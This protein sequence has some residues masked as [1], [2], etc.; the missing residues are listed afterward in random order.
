MPKV[1]TC[2]LRCDACF[3]ALLSHL[4]M[5]ICQ[6]WV[7][8]ITL[9]NLH[10]STTS[11]KVASNLAWVSETRCYFNATFVYKMLIHAVNF[12][13][14]WIPITISAHVNVNREIIWENLWVKFF[15]AWTTC[16][17]G[18]S[19]LFTMRIVYEISV[20]TYTTTKT[21]EQQKFFRYVVCTCTWYVHLRS[22]S[23]LS[24]FNLPMECL[25]K[26]HIAI[27]KG[28]MSSVVHVTSNLMWC[29][30]L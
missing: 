8:T 14:I 7:V 6:W 15:V 5:L 16:K 3:N 30:F 17:N 28:R 25:Y 26:E 4:V 24:L 11:N 20:H 2:V 27:V 10:T 13:K 18:C 23:I 9:F 1:L 22:I 29:H 19:W 21:F 12:E